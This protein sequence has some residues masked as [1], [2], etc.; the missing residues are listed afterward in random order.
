VPV[1]PFEIAAL[2]EN[3]GLATSDFISA[4]VEVPKHE[5]ARKEDGSCVFLNAEGCSVYSARPLACRLY[6]L[7]REQTGSGKERF[8][9]LTPEPTSTGEVSDDG[10]VAQYLDSQQTENYLKVADEYFKLFASLLSAL[11]RQAT[12]AERIR[13]LVLADT[14]IRTQLFSSKTRADFVTPLFDID[15]LLS[16]HCNSEGFNIPEDLAGRIKLHQQVVAE[17]IAELGDC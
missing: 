9:V 15:K 3:H 16:K 1:N 10:T 5:L 12:D 4:Y 14:S 6:P 13:D 7:A 2:A 17:L 11:Q 8:V